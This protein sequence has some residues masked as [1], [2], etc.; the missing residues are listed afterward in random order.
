MTWL[1]IEWIIALSIGLGCLIAYWFYRRFQAY[2]LRRVDAAASA[3]ILDS[4]DGVDGE[5]ILR[6]PL[7]EFP[8]ADLRKGLSEQSQ[9]FQECAR[10]LHRQFDSRFQSILFVHGTFA[11]NDPFG[12]IEAIP[13]N[14]F[15][16]TRVLKKF[17][18]KLVKLGHD[19]V[20]Q[21]NG[22][23]LPGYIGLWDDILLPA[24]GCKRFHWSSENHHLG[25]LQAA[26]NLLREVLS[27]REL[28]PGLRKML[29]VG[30]SHAGQ[31]FALFTQI[32]FKP[33]VTSKLEDLDL[34][35]FSSEELRVLKQMDF[36]FVTL[37]APVRYSFCLAQQGRLLHLINDRSHIHPV[38][39]TMGMFKSKQGDYIQTLGSHGSDFKALT[40]RQRE[41]NRVLEELLLEGFNPAQL[42][43]NLRT[44]RMVSPQG[45]TVLIDFADESSTSIQGIKNL[46]GHGVYTRSEHLLFIIKKVLEHSL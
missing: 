12:I 29:L 34:V 27:L 42:I 13:E 28:N 15:I 40:K 24:F 9:S 19:R 8:Q 22:N 30:H 39:P 3:R 36:S 45:K 46:F 32:L 21:D 43:D 26:A 5:T 4:E 17:A 11:G 16:P 33:E 10:R 37:G 20:L 7:E 18:S 6:L 38:D 41:A 23:F 35:H 2:R 14:R 25:R 31:V 44:N 1:T